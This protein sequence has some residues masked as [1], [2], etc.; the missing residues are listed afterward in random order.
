MASI[1]EM[2]EEIVLKLFPI[3]NGL[4][5]KVDVPIKGV[6]FERAH[7]LFDHNLTIGVSVIVS[8]H[9]VDNMLVRISFTIELLKLQLPVASRHP[10]KIYP[11]RVKLGIYLGGLKL[12]FNLVIDFLLDELLQLT[13][14]DNFI[15]FW[16]QIFCNLK[17]RILTHCMNSCVILF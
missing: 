12:T 16:F 13:R 7:K 15:S 5:L 9:K 11:L 2:I 3:T 17:D 8:F 6:A 1:V 10:Q 4:K 14:S